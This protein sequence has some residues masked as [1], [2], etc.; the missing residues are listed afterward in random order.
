MTSTPLPLQLYLLFDTTLSS[1]SLYPDRSG[2][3]SFCN[4]SLRLDLLAKAAV[5]ARWF[6]FGARETTTENEKASRIMK[7]MSS[8]PLD[9]SRK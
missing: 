6:H 4:F 7:K 1:S 2:T 9:N 3:R 8:Q 5:A